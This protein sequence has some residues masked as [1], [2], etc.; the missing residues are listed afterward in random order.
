MLRRVRER[1]PTMILNLF[2]AGSWLAVNNT[3]SGWNA[4]ALS[5]LFHESYYVPPSAFNQGVCRVRDTVG[6]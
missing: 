2:Y 3:A 5:S 4:R 6:G 1:C